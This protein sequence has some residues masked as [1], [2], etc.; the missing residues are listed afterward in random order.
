MTDLRKTSVAEPLVWGQGPCVLEVFLEPTCPFSAKAFAKLDPLLSR[1]GED[2]LTVKI[3]LLSQ[4]WHLF[5]G[6]VTRSILAASATDNGKARAKKVMACVFANRDD[7][8]FVDHCSGPNL[9]RTPNEIIELISIYSGIDLADAFK[10]R[11]LE[12]EMKWHAKYSRQNG[13]HVSP[14]F[15]VD[16]LIEPRLSSADPVE[17]WIEVLALD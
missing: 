13:I 3:R 8:E 15:M 7:F 10:I 17:Q 11:E 16:G 14:S 9:R 12:R 1:A 6:I 4:P 5:S 2:R